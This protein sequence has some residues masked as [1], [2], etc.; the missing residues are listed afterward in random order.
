L[1]AGLL[2]AASGNV[3][4]AQSWL[5]RNARLELRREGPS[6]LDLSAFAQSRREDGD[7][8]RDRS[9][10]LDRSVERQDVSSQ[11]SQSSRQSDSTSR[12]SKDRPRQ[13]KDVE[14]T[15]T[16][17]VDYTSNAIRASTETVVGRG[18]AD[19]H[20]HPDIAAKWSHQYDWAKL[21]ATGGVGFDR[22]FEVRD[23]DENTMF[24]SFKMAFTDG[25][26]D[27]FVPYLSYIGL[28]GFEPDFSFRT[29]I[30]NDANVGFT[31]GIGFDKNGRVIGYKDASKD[32]ESSLQLDLRLTRRMAEP[33]SQDMVQVMAAL[34][35]EY[36]FN[37]EWKLNLAPR[38]RVRWYDDFHG[39]KRRDIRPS[40]IAK[41]IWTPEWLTQ[42]MP[43][44][45]IDFILFYQRNFSNLREEEY[46]VWE[47]GPTVIFAWKL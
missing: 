27:L 45:E 11:E 40:V 2:T 18:Q 17:P 31:S 46:V 32:G 36:I 38:V 44:A 47:L 23:A 15:V 19:V 34:E 26:S 16:L 7:S 37:K 22:Y 25:K 28:A 41:A 3:A 35:Y 24:W 42:V 10:R 39:E 43:R 9:D 30:L 29:D 1:G 33:S 4:Q 20:F 12:D 13:S 5:D 8:L 6:P 14:V 21:T